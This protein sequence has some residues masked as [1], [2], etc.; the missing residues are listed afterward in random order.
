[1]S[2]ATATKTDVHPFEAAREVGRE[3]FKVADLAQA[4]LGRKE[5]RLAEHEMPGLMAVREKYGAEKPLAHPRLRRELPHQK[6]ER[7]DGER[8]GGERVVGQ[9]FQLRGDHRRPPEHNPD[10]DGARQE[11]GDAD[12][13]AQEDQEKHQREA[14]E[15][16]REPVHYARTSP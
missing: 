2:V 8:V 10:A 4:E 1:M 6:E 7:H 9:R 16:E 3:P 15:G 5:I 12:R 13:H 11:E 14:E